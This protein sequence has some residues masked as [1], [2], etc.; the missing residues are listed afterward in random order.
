MLIRANQVLR[1]E[2]SLRAFRRAIDY[3]LATQQGDGNWVD[4]HWADLD[5]TSHPVSFFNV[6]L[7]LDEPYRRAEVER[8]WRAGLRF[9]LDAQT[10]D[11]GWIDPEFH[12]SGVEITAHLIQDAL[13]ADL[14]LDA[15]V[16]G[17][18]RACAKGLAKLARVQSES[19]SWDDDNV[20]HTL[21]CV[22][23]SMLVVRLLADRAPDE[24]AALGAAADL[25]WIE[26]GF[27]W[28]LAVKN[29]EGWGD[30][31]QRASNL[32]RTCDGVDTLVKYAAYRRHDAAA[33]ARL[34]GYA[35]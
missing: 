31:P 33:I 20:D 7:A 27:A 32:E 21:D 28:V 19:G 9:I 15:C 3:F 1:D 5:T 29:D 34:W 14:L 24:L 4:P 35:R 12:P 8:S 2:Q 18:A 26:R 22:R 30:F 13:V 25:R 11:G 17:V 23:S 16:A 6:V 10:G